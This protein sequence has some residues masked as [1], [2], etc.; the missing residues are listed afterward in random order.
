[1][2]KTNYK[3]CWLCFL[4]RFDNSGVQR[5]HGQSRPKR[6]DSYLQAISSVEVNTHYQQHQQHQ[7]VQQTNYQADRR[8]QRSKFLIQG[9][10]MDYPQK[11][12][13]D[14]RILK[15]SIRI[16]KNLNLL[17]VKAGATDKTH[18]SKQLAIFPLKENREVKKW[19]LWFPQL[20]SSQ[21]VKIRRF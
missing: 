15:K 8:S 11:K 13:S 7:S 3:A 18:I 6:Q 16:R 4:F 21:L 1:M 5:Q 12:L 9:F 20:I 2:P 17:Q 14:S 19:L 10:S